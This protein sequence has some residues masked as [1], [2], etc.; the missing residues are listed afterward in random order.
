MRRTNGA[1]WLLFLTSAYACVM[2]CMRQR[3]NGG[4]EDEMRISK[5]RRTHDDDDDDDF[6]LNFSF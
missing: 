1:E 4:K 5:H 6:R 3:A 2:R